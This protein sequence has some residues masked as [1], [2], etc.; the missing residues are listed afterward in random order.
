MALNHKVDNRISG[1]KDHY[2]QIFTFF[3]DDIMFGLDVDNVLMLGQ[4]L[5]AIQRLPL[6]ERGLCGVINFQGIAVPV[7]D[8]AHRLGIAS[9]IDSKTA[10]LEVL[11]IAEKEHL[12]W[13]NA[14]ESTLKNGTEFMLSLDPD[15]C[16][17]GQWYKAFETRDETLLELLK[18]FDEPHQKIHN[19]ATKLISMRNQG[20]ERAA[21]TL[22]TQ[23]RTSTLARLRTL[24]VR[25]HDQIQSNMRQVLLF[26]TVDGKKPHY[27]LK[28]DDI[29]DVIN[30]LP[31]QFQPTHGSALGLVQKIEDMLEGIFIRDNLPNCLYFNISKLTDSTQTQAIP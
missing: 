1:K 23:E 28:I 12:E 29:N 2:R 14:L 8:F 15:G 4:D 18:E 10:L 3:V 7:F 19:L 26:V 9:G 13:M 25:A 16:E 17:F 22:L 20:D 24:F 21:L 31:S 5:S 6:E 30:Y 11:K 27:A